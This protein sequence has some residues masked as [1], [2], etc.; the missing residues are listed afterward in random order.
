MTIYTGDATTVQLTPALAK[1][2]LNM[3]ANSNPPGQEKTERYTRTMT[4]GRFTP[5][6]IIHFTKGKMVN[7]RHRC[8]AVIASGVTIQVTLQVKGEPRPPTT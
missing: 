3:R 5:D 7:G 2:W 6:S 1:A 4:A 8:A